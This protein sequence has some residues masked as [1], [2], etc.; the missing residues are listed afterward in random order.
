MGGFNLPPGCTVGDIE[1]AMGDDTITQRE[2]KILMLL[3]DEGVPTAY[4]DRIM[5]IV[6]EYELSEAQSGDDQI[7]Y[8][9]APR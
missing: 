2:E 4:N 6:R 9:D 7:A 3:E 5:A 1:R 8:Y